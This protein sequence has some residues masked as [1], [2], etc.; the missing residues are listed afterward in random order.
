MATTTILD[1]IMRWKREELPKRKRALPEAELRVRLF[2]APPTRDFAAAM[3]AP[4]ISLIAECK[5]A[6]P[7]KGLLRAGYDPVALARNYEAGGAR[8]ISVLTDSR[9]FQGTI[10]H[11]AAVRQ[12][13]SLPVLRKEFIFDPYQLVE[14][15][16]AGAD[17]VLLIA[18]VLSGNRLRE[19]REEAEAL[20]M[21]ALVEVHDEAELA[22]ALDSGASIIGVNN[23]D[24]R[25][26]EVDFET[27]ARLRPLI[28]A[29]KLLIAESG[30]RTTADVQRLA[31]SG[32]DGMLVGERLV[33]GK[34]DV[35]ARVRE[36]VG[37]G[38]G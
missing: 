15:R 20:G 5:K 9:Y 23:R 19:L 33:K 4:G 32:V 38:R 16:A 2:L 36:L 3:R 34:G 6:S 35:T 28:P 18:A 17:A 22:H 8:A 1:E 26:F 14:A 30:I 27:T 31:E 7:S 21:V 29:D 37:A 25:T 10:E 12:A 11:L 24:L 13:V